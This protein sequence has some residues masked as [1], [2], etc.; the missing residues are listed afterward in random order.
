MHQYYQ[1]YSHPYGFNPPII[2]N[3]HPSPGLS[4]PEALLKPGHHV[5][6]QQQII[7]LSINEWDE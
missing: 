5:Y 2:Y 1:A 6:Q 4:P 3:S 7:E